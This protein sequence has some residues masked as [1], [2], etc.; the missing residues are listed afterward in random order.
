MAILMSFSAISYLQENS[1]HSASK[2]A[3]SAS[4]HILSNSLRRYDPDILAKNIL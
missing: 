4:F 1:G 2:G 3:T